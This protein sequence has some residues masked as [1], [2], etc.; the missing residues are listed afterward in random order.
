M[1]ATADEAACCN[2]TVAGAM[3][4]AEVGRLEEWIHTYLGVA[5]WANPGLSNGL[6]LKERF[7]V[8]PAEVLLCDIDRHCGPEPEMEFREPAEQWERRIEAMR[9]SIHSVTDLPPLILD[10]RNGTRRNVD[11]SMRFVCAD[12]THR[13]EALR[14][15][16]R[17]RCFGVIW[18]ETDDVRAEYLAERGGVVGVALPQ[19]AT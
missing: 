19:V 14:R 10:A 8:G 4:W 7:W 16:G 13:L 17:E 9:A 15:Q 18:F 1:S 6:K 5:E 12:G 11:G 2:W 3:R